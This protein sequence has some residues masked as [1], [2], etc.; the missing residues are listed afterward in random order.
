MMPN[1][2]HKRRTDREKAYQDLRKVMSNVSNRGRAVRDSVPSKQPYRLA[3]ERI[4]RNQG[5][6]TD[7]R[8]Q[9][10]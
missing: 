2:A 3:S 5:S 10:V 6:I 9:I 4:N 8:D 7:S 1:A